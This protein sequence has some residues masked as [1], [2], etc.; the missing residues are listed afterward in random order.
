MLYPTTLEEKLDY[1]QGR[2]QKAA[3][4]AGRKPKDITLI[5]ITKS[6][7]VEMWEQALNVNL[8][9]I[10]ESRIKETEEKTIFQ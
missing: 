6:F 5:G 2:I 1:I 8:T 10:G 7:P 9:T 4:S 3:V